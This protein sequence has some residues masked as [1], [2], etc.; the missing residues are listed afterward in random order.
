LQEE[1][2]A[3]GSGQS[4]GQNRNSTNQP[5]NEQTTRRKRQRD[6]SNNSKTKVNDNRSPSSQAK[7]QQQ[8][9]NK[10]PKTDTRQLKII[11]LG[12]LDDIGKNMAVFE[13]ENDIILVDAGLMF[14][15]DD[16]P[17]VDL[18]LPDYTY[19]LEHAE[20]LRGIVITHGHED[21]TGALPY[22]LKDLG[23][24][25]PIYGSKLTLGLIE[26][27]LSE[28]RIKTTDFREVKS[29]QKVK[30]GAFTCEF[31]SVS[32]SIPASL[33][34][35]LQT[36]VATVLH[37]GDFKL[38][39]TPID[40]VHTDFAAIAR[41]AEAGIDILLS[42][43]TNAVT[44]SFTKSE[45]E[46]GKCLEQLIAGS[47]QR[48]IV[49]AF[50][51]HIHRVQQ[52]CDAAIAAG[53][54]VAVTGRS[55]ITN[56]QIARDLGYLKVGD[57]HIIDAYAA[58]D[59][60]PHKVVI[61]CTGSQGE[62]LSALARMAN[63]EHRTVEI[64]EGDIVIIAATP[65]PGNEKAVNR[66]VN[67]LSKIGAEVYDKKRALVHVSG[68]AA[69]EELKLLLTLAKPKHFMPIHGEALHLRA[70]AK[71]AE[72]VGIPR[73]N[74]FIVDSGD[75]LLLNQQ[76]VVKGEPIES[77]IIYVD[78]LSVGD[79]S[80]VV[81]K[82]RQTL[83]SDGI[84]TLVCMIRKRDSSP[85]GTPEV[86]MRGVIGGE[87]PELL[88]DA[89]KVVERTM[90]KFAHEHRSNPNRLKRALREALLRFLWERIRMRPMVIPIIMDI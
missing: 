34:V 90:T 83:A 59:I 84:V 4:T 80:N 42:D 20:K 63:G 48:V 1:R 8:K 9:Q 86:I 82:D 41:F 74:I 13:F 32:H 11:P 24:T 35:F 30:L 25:V 89:V 75:V 45:A 70:H 43:S 22:L 29:G 55:M 6:R 28:H 79:V 68:H 65:V 40:G 53:R 51:S 50:S 81:L 37:T 61:L 58:K 52:V 54:K 46:V 3:T 85:I 12:G 76:G 66:V 62:P 14:P 5:D 39:Q 44:E 71:L 10:P 23:F 60:P 26:G 87:D 17:G 38:D 47:E 57:R 27:K 69:S 72:D 49:A 78:G 36:P 67:A 77:G 64:T 2:N 7:P 19:V 73:K 15:D 16:H 31:F 56:S 33:G 21:H 18:I 88:N